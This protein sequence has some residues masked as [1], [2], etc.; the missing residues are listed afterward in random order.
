MLFK[1]RKEPFSVYF[2]WLGEENKGREVIYVAGQYQGKLHTKIAAGDIPFMPAGHRTAL[3]PN[4]F[5]VR[6]NS[7]HAITEAGIGRVIDRF[8]SVVN[9]VESG[10]N[11]SG[12]LQYLG[13]L[14]RPEYPEELEAVLHTIP[15]GLEKQLPRGGQRF[16]YF[17]MDLRFPVLVITRDHNRQIV[18][19]YCYDRFLFPGRMYDDEFNPDVLWGK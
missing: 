6:S 17:D 19:Y 12:T 11:R 3:S 9:A 13:K 14:K 5:L 2:K 7:R 8:G 18:E 16:L 15:A 10:N 1:F 4:S